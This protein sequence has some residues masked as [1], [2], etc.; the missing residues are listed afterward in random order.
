MKLNLA[1]PFTHRNKLI[2]DTELL[3]LS[4]NF[5]KNKIAY[6]LGLVPEFFSDNPGRV[7]L[8]EYVLQSFLAILTNRPSSEYTLDQLT[9]TINFRHLYHR[10]AKDVFDTHYFTVSINSIYKWLYSNPD[11]LRLVCT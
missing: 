1:L 11:I 6:E 9:H 2:Y 7:E 8:S 10:I 4:E 5:I 3:I